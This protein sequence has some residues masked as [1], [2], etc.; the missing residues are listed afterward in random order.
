MQIFIPNTI[1]LHYYAIPPK[2]FYYIILRNQELVN[3]FREYFIN[4]S[5]FYKFLGS[6]KIRNS[7]LDLF[8][9]N[10]DDLILKKIHSEGDHKETMT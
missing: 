8:M 4:F 2:T 7:L 6:L 10:E 9:R 5:Q 1:I 3:L